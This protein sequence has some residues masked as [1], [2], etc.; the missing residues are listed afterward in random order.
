MTRAT[1]EWSTVGLVATARAASSAAGSI[2]V[3]VVGRIG[4]TTAK[5]EV[6][7]GVAV[8]SGVVDPPTDAALRD[9]ATAIGPADAAMVRI[10][11]TPTQV[12]TTS[13]PRRGP[14]RL[15]CACQRCAI[16]PPSRLGTFVAGSVPSNGA[17]AGSC[18]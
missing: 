13:Q 7:T 10:P 14:R 5:S 4:A 11:R 15:G 1:R 2:R 17:I 16:G 18:P 6:G 8:G 12:V 3:T 9:W